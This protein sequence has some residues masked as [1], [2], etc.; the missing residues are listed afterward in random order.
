MGTGREEHLRAQSKAWQSDW[1]S[2]GSR[3]NESSG[4]EEGADVPWAGV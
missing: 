3:A 2:A 4:E 1:R